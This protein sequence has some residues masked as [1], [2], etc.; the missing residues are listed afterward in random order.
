MP[1]VSVHQPNFMPW[2]KLLAKVLASDVFIAYDTVQFT[3]REFHARQLIDNGSGTPE[4]LTVPVQ[5][6][7]TRQRLCEVQVVRDRDW[8]SD[9]LERLSAAY[10]RSPYFSEVFPL[11]QAAYDQGY[12]LLVDHN[13]AILESMC[14]YLGSKVRIVRASELDH[15]GTREERLLELVRGCGGDA[16]LTSTTATHVVD[17]SGFDRAGIPVYVQDFNE[18]SYP[19]GTKPFTPHLAAADLLFNCGSASGA[20]LA[21]VSSAALRPADIGAGGHQGSDWLQENTPAR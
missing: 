16:H 4:W 20:L 17:W 6:T 19:Q 14:A 8:R 13:L 21:S 1:M 3:R 15:S 2:N 5:G 12:S 18:P 7:G 9:H 11:F 10:G